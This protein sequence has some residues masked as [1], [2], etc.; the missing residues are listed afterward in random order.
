MAD[1]TQYQDNEGELDVPEQPLAQD[2]DTPSAPPDDVPADKDVPID[3]PDTDTDNDEHEMYDAGPAAAAGVNA[4]HEEPT[5]EE[6]RI[7]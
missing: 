4:Q 1:N 5:E 7:A 6:E 3:H 2:Y